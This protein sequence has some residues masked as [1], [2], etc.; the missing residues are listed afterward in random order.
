MH[1]Y[2]S[3]LKY[4]PL[5]RKDFASLIGVSISQ[6]TNT[7]RLLTLSDTIKKALKDDKLS[8]GHARMLVGLSESE[9]EYYLQEILDNKYSVRDIEKQISMHKNNVREDC[10]KLKK[11]SATYHISGNGQKIT[12]D[13]NSK[14]E[15]NKFIKKINK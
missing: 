11:Y 10:F 3:I 4:Y 5:S 13:F 9:Q 6:I 8:Y 14:E 1:G 2:D 15:L 12:F 7:L